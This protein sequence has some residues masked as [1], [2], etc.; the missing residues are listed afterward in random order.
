MQQ[1]GK[2]AGTK[3]AL[4]AVA[5]AILWLA[6]AGGGLA[7]DAPAAKPDKPAATAPAN[8]TVVL[9][10]STLWRHFLITRCAFVRGADGKLQAQDLTPLTGKF[11]TWPQPEPRPAASTEPSPLPPKDWAGVSMDDSA[12]PRV[13]LPQPSPTDGDFRARPQ[14]RECGTA[15]VLLRGRFEVNDPAQVKTCRLSLDYWGG[16]VVYLNGTEVARRH[17]AGDKPDLLALAEDYPTEAFITP[18]GKPNILLGFGD[19]KWGD[20][21]E[22]ARRLALRQRSARGVALPVALLKPGV[23][24]LALEVHTAPCYNMIDITFGRDGVGWPWVPIGL[25]HA[26]LTL[27][28]AGAVVA[29]IKRPAGIRVR[30]VGAA[31]TVTAFD[32]GDPWDAVRPIL[33]YAARNSVFSGRLVVDSDQPIKG[34]KASVT[35]LAQ[36]Q[37]G[38]KLPASSIRVR[39]A[40]AAGPDKTQMSPHRYDGLLDT[41]PAEIPVFKETPDSQGNY[42]LRSGSS[43][44]LTAGAVAPLWFTVRV[45]KDAKPGVYE[46]QVTVS[47]EGLPPTAVPLRVSVSDWATPDPK[48]FRMHNLAYHADDALAWHYDV[49]LWS[50]R[51]FELMGRSHALMADVGSRQVYLNLG[52]SGIF[53]LSPNV[54]VLRWVKQPDGSA[55]PD[56]TVLDK[57]LDMVAASVG[58]PLPLRL[59]IWNA[60]GE[61][62]PK[63]PTAPLLHPAT[64]TI[65]RISQPAFDTDEAAAFWRPVFAEVLNRI[66]ARGWLDV[67]ALGWV[68]GQS[69]PTEEVVELAAKVWPEAV[70]ACVTHDMKRNYRVGNPWVKI[71]YAGT[72]YS[73]GFPS[74]RG[75]RELLKPQAEILCNTYRWNWNANSLLST[76]RRVGEDIVMSGRDGVSDFGADL[77]PFKNPRGGYTTAQSVQYPSG[78]NFTFNAL[79]Y[80]GPDGPVP[81]ERY[82][83]FREGVELAEA[84]L[85]VE[86]AIQDKK[87]SPALQERAEKA[88][89]ARGH[90]FIMNWFVIRDMTGTDEDAKLLALAGEVA[91]ELEGK[92]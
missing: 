6:G 62:K 67:T 28:P 84:L 25:H 82:E 11:H 61:G 63:P 42:P 8:E 52:Q 37:T 3:R 48:D 5:L 10:D 45:P 26:Q 49:P 36:A 69:P 47:A 86:R 74:V 32:Y 22:N 1:T 43:S 59:N 4:G 23:N 29:N 33:I 60:A 27:S 57:Y 18:N 81:T 15:T 17:V 55:K 38:A 40:V 80:P 58:T 51:H 13:R 12:W 20:K 79:L 24:V 73:Y 90:A 70:W 71:R 34:L 87:L 78:P 54:E 21:K 41:I 31:D 92:K 7:A 75:Y 83:M 30:N 72:C 46:G 65:E 85:F 88:L 35:D 39:Y 53:P 50:D 66:K 2:S 64:N 19:E 89:E 56:F 9:D 76:Y 77:V 44:N 16:V 91:K 14:R 68:A